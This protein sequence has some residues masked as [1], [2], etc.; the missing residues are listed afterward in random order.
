LIW[1]TKAERD[2]RIYRV[3][4]ASMADWLEDHPDWIE[5]RARLEEL[6]AATPNLIWLFLTKRPENWR[7]IPK[8]WQ[9]LWPVNAMFGFTAE[10]QEWFDK[11]V[12]HISRSG[13]FWNPLLQATISRGLRCFLSAEPL[14]GQIDIRDDARCFSQVI[15]GGESGSR[16]RPM[17]PDWARSLRDQCADAG[18]PFFMK[19][20][21]DERGRKT[22]I[23]ADLLVRQTPHYWPSNVGLLVKDELAVV[24]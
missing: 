20:M 9:K 18:V 23:P 11:R 7:L 5:P 21:C 19:Q 12:C 16:A 3:F 2:G 13:G 10:N 1:N 15:C 17:H 6:V 4:C 24:G 22:D 14:L 8:A